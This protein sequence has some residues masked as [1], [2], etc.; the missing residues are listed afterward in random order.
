MYAVV[1]RPLEL[2]SYP[3]LPP[4]RGQ[5]LALGPSGGSGPA[6]D[7]WAL[8]GA[9]PVFGQ[10]PLRNQPDLITVKA[11]KII[12]SHGEQEN[13]KLTWMDRI[14]S[15]AFTLLFHYPVHP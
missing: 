11:L 4:Y 12:G 15:L 14:T 8:H 1:Q 2:R 5:Q 9:G 13:P 10:R 7:P 6:S 3:V